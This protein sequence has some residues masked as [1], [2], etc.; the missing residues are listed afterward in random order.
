MDK[1]AYGQRLR[2]ELTALVADSKE[3][4]DSRKPV[5][6]DQQSV[7]RLSRMDAMQVQAMAVAG[8]SRRQVRI[9]VL[10]AAL[11]RIG[12]DEFGFCAR[13]GDEISEKRL[14]L[15]PAIATCV[16]CA[17]GTR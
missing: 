12:T 17:S 2:D 13:C 8:E 7:G 9:Q 4:E 14:D 15:D 10:R 6:L 11:G 3:A 16:D 5:A 1:A